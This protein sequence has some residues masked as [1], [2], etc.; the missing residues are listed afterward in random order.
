[1]TS[2]V[3]IIIT[4]LYQI[5]IFGSGFLFLRWLVKLFSGAD[6]RLDKEE[7]KKL[8]AF[9]LF[10]SSFI[11]VLYKEA[12]RPVSTEHIF[13]ETWLFFIISGLLT[14]LSLDKIFDAF[15]VL[16]E[17]LIRLKTPKTKENNE[18]TN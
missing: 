12:N 4:I 7:F 16:L 6:Q 10:L 2:Y 18:T 14:V 15:K 1:M 11:Y 9:I 3:P 13:S 17:I 8:V 5:L